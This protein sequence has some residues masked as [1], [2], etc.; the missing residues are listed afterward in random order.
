[1]AASSSAGKPELRS[2]TASRTLPRSSTWIDTCTRSCSF[3][4]TAC[5]GDFR[6]DERL[7]MPLQAIEE[8]AV[9]QHRSGPDRAGPSPGIAVAQA[10]SSARSS[11][12]GGDGRLTVG[13]YRRQARPGDQRGTAA[14]WGGG[15]SILTAPGSQRSGPARRSTGPAVSSV[16]PAPRSMI[17][18]LDL[19]RSP[20]SRAAAEPGLARVSACLCRNGSAGVDCRLRAGSMAGVNGACPADTGSPACPPPPP[21][22]ARS[23]MRRYRERPPSRRPGRTGALRRITRRGRHAEADQRRQMD[24]KR[25]TWR[26]AS[27]GHAGHRRF[28]GRGAVHTP[29]QAAQTRAVSSAFPLYISGAIALPVL[30]AM[31]SSEIRCAPTR[32]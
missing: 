7:Q 11:R 19:P 15:V 30:S 17:E 18:A 20:C 5:R 4:S 8:S 32:V 2:I 29:P 27:P 12:H 21:P 10:S 26:V 3:R 25:G 28:A 6:A 24:E 22:P 13:D 9:R 1:M 14:A 16:A 31:P 23:T